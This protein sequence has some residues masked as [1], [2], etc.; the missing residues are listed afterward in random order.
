MSFLLG[1]VSGALV[2][3]G[4]YFGFKTMIQERTERHRADLHVLSTRLADASAAAPTTLPAA[5]RIE[6]RPLLSA[7]KSQWNTQVETVFRGIGDLNKKAVNWSKQTLY[8]GYV[9]SKKQ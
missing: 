1:P 5:L 8:G 3:G 9:E 7:V 2:A 4:V 6:H